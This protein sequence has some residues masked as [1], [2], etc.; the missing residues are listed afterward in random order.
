MRPAVCTCNCLQ[1]LPCAHR[2]QP[3]KRRRSEAP[4]C[5]CACHLHLP[6]SP[7]RLCLLLLRLHLPLSPPR[8]CLLLLRRLLPPNGPYP[9]PLCPSGCLIHQPPSNSTCLPLAP[10]SGLAI[11][12]SRFSQVVAFLAVARRSRQCLDLSMSYS[13]SKPPP[14]RP[15]ACA[16]G[17]HTSPGAAQHTTM[18]NTA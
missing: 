5:C 11:C 2:V 8:L 17:A 4:N 7:P 14:T 12:L 18:T 3:P 15:K 13:S 1:P 16:G 10:A 6:L 9:P